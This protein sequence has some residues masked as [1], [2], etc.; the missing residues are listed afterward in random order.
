[1]NRL[2]A[3]LEVPGSRNE[4]MEGLRGFSA[5]IVFGV[6]WESM[7]SE[8]VK[9]STILSAATEFFANMGHLGV[10]IF[11]IL[12]GYLIYGIVL[13]GG[14]YGLFMR[15]R[16]QRIYPVFACTYLIYLVAALT[17]ETGKMPHSLRQG[18]LYAL[19]NFLLLPGIFRIT[20]LITVAWSLSYEVFFYL[21][22]PILA[23][24]IRRQNGRLWMRIAAFV[25]AAIA[26]NVLY[27]GHVWPWQRM[28]MFVVGMILRELQPTA[29][30]MGRPSAGAEAGALTAFSGYLVLA[31][32]AR[33]HILSDKSPWLGWYGAPLFG[34]C[35]GYLCW[36]ALFRGGFTSRLFSFTPLRWFGNIS[37]S[38]YM[39]HGLTL[40]VLQ[41]LTGVAHVGMLGFGASTLL[42][43]VA[44]SSTV[45]VAAVM[46]FVVEK[47]LSLAP[48]IA[49]SYPA[50]ARAAAANQ[51]AL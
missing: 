5:L 19:A 3:A 13:K 18:A 11:F 30:R 40:G 7:F 35:A 16:L 36:S 49:K 10:D 45:L 32:L 33:I 17:T 26:M 14:S 23:V 21:A 15:R 31:G 41:R 46:F 42:L 25:L 44:F 1:M 20:P 38:Y 47:P 4:A 37:Y 12:S 8:T 43:A 50:L 28:Q 6:H 48:A 27:V 22:I 51:M 29:Q 39:T 2:A 34:I 24:G 9:A